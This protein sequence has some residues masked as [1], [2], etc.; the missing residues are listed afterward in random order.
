[1]KNILLVQ[2]DFF[3][4]TIE[5]LDDCPTEGLLNLG[6]I[7]T[8]VYFETTFDFAVDGFERNIDRSH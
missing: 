8:K 1:M 7:D 6:L 2:P 3:F 5:E 4:V